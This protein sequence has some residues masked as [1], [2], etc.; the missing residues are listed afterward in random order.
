MNDSISSLFLLGTLAKDTS[1][2]RH[3][4]FTHVPECVA[5]NDRKYEFTEESSIAP[6]L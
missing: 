3:G 5:E 6:E 4:A 2:K 1:Q